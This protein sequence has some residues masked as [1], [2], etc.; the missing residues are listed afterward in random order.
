MYDHYVELI[1]NMG[2]MANKYEVLVGFYIKL[3]F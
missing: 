3:A 1:K 2:F